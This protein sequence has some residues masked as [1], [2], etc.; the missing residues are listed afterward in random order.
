MPF[1]DCLNP[2]GTVHWAAPNIQYFYD[3]GLLAGYDVNGQLYARP[4]NNMTRAEFAVL[5]FR[6]L[7]LDAADYMEADVPYADISKID[8]WAL[9]AAKAMYVLGIMKGSGTDDGK[10]YF[11]PADTVTRAQAITMLG[12]LQEKGYT[13]A[14]L[15]QF[16]DATDVPDWATAHLKTMVAQGVINGSDGKLL[17][18]ASMTRAQALKV[19]SLMR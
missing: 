1:V 18:N 10:A 12:R 16:T 5:L 19:L 17:P 8:P 15:T 9:D 11:S 2:D 4:N 13:S 3:Q 7:G 6:Y 14:E